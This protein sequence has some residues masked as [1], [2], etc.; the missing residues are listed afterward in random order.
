MGTYEILLASPVIAVIAIA[1]LW[2]P[3]RI[4]FGKI[5]LPPENTP[6][7]LPEISRFSTDAAFAET[8]SCQDDIAARAIPVPMLERRDSALAVPMKPDGAPAATL[9][10]ARLVDVSGTYNK[11]SFSIPATGV[12][13][14]RNPYKAEIVL[15]NPRISSRH[16]WIG[17]VDGKPVLRDLNSTNGTFLNG[18][19]ITPNTEVVLS[20]G[21]TIFF[22]NCRGERFRFVTE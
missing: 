10:G 1:A 22:A 9:T 7:A 11:R 8:H 13:I 18:H 20:P 16:A 6:A 19:V 17:F 3:Y 2:M 5:D 12:T 21:D 14:G 4:R 15:R